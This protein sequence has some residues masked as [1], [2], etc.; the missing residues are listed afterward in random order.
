MLIVDLETT[1]VNPKKNSIVSIGAIDFLHPE[2]TFYEEC[3]PWNGAEIDDDALA[4]NGFTKEQILDEDRKT[5]Y[6]AMNNFLKWVSE[7][8][9]QTLGGHNFGF[10]WAFL[11]ETA[12]IY[13][14]SWKPH[15][16]IVDLHSVCYTHHLKRGIIPPLKDNRTDLSFNK[17][18]NYVGLPD[19]PVPHN[20]LFGAKAAAEAFSRLLY[21]KSLLDEFKKHPL[22]D[23][24]KR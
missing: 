17:V 3:R 13:N 24:L 4:V 18:L 20:A 19:E 8:E 1:G 7:S 9:N 6:E 5:L 15:R 16:R 11:K 23:Y 21:G 2:R 22:P 10:D 14:L 12:E